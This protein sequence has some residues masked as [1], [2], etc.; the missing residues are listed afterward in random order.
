MTPRAVLSIPM[1]SELRT[2]RD[3]FRYAV[4]RFNAAD[5]SYGHGAANA[6][7]EAAYLVLEALRLPID[8]IDPFLDARLL[9]DERA[10]LA[11]L[12]EARVGERKPAAYLV[13]RAYMQGVPFEIDER[14]IVP[15]SFIGELLDGELFA[16]GP[17]A[18]ASNPESVESVLD[19]CTGSGC[20]AILAA[21]AF[22]A[23]QVD[24]VEL[25]PAALT[26]ARKN[27]ATSGCLDRI[28]LYEGDLYNPLPKKRYD[29][30][31]SNPPYVDACG[32]AALPAEYLHEPRMAL[33]GGEDGLDVVR[34]ILEGAA[35]RLAPGGGLL[36]EVGRGRENLEAAFPE[37]PFL[38]L[39]TEESQ[40]EVFWL[41]AGN[42]PRRRGGRGGP[43]PSKST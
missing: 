26:V 35:A 33:D 36:C 29:I 14:V 31:L 7:D 6:V 17:D 10:R 34:R 40:G 32:M 18:L 27:V 9:P 20:L 1:T 43:A 37:T 28:R 3:F 8:R 11:G 25:S 23:A 21:R 41:P 5:L 16:G 24:A 2:I 39:D 4:S 42:V 38:W 19:L 22:P 13:G 12:I 15:R 30:I